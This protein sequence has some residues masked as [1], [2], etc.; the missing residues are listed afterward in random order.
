MI[1]CVQNKVRSCALKQSDKKSDAH[2]FSELYATK[3]GPCDQGIRHPDTIIGDETALP[4][5]MAYSV[6]RPK[7]LI[8]LKR[9]GW[10]L[11]S[12]LHK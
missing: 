1:S 12:S 3:I 6:R 10:S 8:K 9:Q 7:P 11:I 4:R 5:R 2:I